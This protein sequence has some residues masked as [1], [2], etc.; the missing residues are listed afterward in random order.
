MSIVFL[1]PVFQLHWLA[2]AA[3]GNVLQVIGGWLM[4]TW[5]GFGLALVLARALSEMSETVDKLWH[6]MAYFTFP[7]SG[8]AF[9]VDSLPQKAQELILYL[10][11]VHGWN[12]CARDGSRPA[13]PRITTCLTWQ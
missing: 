11:M 5:F 3:R 10:P 4:L 12:M 7:L 2:Q 1:K 13:S 6:P 9:L 8:A